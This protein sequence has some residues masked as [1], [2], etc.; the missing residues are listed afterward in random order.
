MLTIISLTIFLLVAVVFFISNYSILGVQDLLIAV[1]DNNVP[2]I[3]ILDNNEQ[4]YNK[5][6]CFSV[7]DV[8]ITEAE[9]DYNGWHRVPSINIKTKDIVKSFDLDPDVKWNNNKII[10]EWNNLI[11]DQKSIC[12]FGAFLQKEKSGNSLWYIQKIKTRKGY[13]DRRT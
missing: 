9:V 11:K 5:W 1:K 10:T 12:I 8:E 2:E 6:Q 7:I 13:W 3:T 4:H